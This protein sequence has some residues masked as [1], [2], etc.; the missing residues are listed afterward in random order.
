MLYDTMAVTF[1]TGFVWCRRKCKGDTVS[2]VT[3]MSVVNINREALILFTRILTFIE[4]IQPI[5]FDKRIGKTKNQSE[6][7]T[8]H[9]LVSSCCSSYSF[10][11][12]L[13]PVHSND[14]LHLFLVLSAHLLPVGLPCRTIF[15]NVS[16]S[17]LVPCE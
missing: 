5:V 10:T 2:L 17:M 6:R 8:D 3:F 14:S 13:K 4:S 9:Q 16:S 11:L 12:G 1:K 15:A 7:Q